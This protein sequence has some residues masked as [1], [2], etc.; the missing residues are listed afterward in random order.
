MALYRAN[1][2]LAEDERI[3]TIP[4]VDELVPLWHEK[5]NHKIHGLICPYP[6]E[7][8]AIEEAGLHLARVSRENNDR[9][10]NKRYTV[11]TNDNKS[12][13]FKSLRKDLENDSA[14]AM[15]AS[16]SATLAQIYHEATQSTLFD[17][18]LRVKPQEISLNTI[19][20]PLIQ[21]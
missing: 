7:F 4:D 16:M 5:A 17:T 21:Y 15:I 13:P 10:Y 3:L 20:T 12:N 11:I 2:R 1:D 6:A 9:F 19:T 18:I 14:P 8:S